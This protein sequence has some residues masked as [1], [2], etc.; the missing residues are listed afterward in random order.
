VRFAPS[1]DAVI[2]DST[3][4][5]AEVLNCALLGERLG[6]DVSSA[7]VVR[8]KP[9]RRL[10][11]VYETSQGP[12]LGKVRA[13][14]RASTPYRL[15]TNLFTS[16]FGDQEPD[17]I[18]VPEPIAVLEDLGVWFQRLVPGRSAT[19]IFTTEE[20]A[21][22]VELAR[23]SA[24]AAHKVH[25]VNIKTRRTHTIYDELQVL[26]RRLSE[27]ECGANS[28]AS[29]IANVRKNC[30]ALGQTLGARPV[31][32]IHRDYYPDQLV[33]D[34]SRVSI[35]DFDLYCAGDPAVDIGNFLAHLTELALR[36]FGD[37]QALRV[38]REAFLTEYLSLAGAQNCFA[39]QVYETLSLARHISLSTEF[40]E[41]RT[42]TENLLSFT[43][44]QL[45]LVGA[46]C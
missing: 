21:E 7:S 27:L 1:G 20:A 6:I 40:A 11:V 36:T 38:L 22:L 44:E 23:R 31:A 26:D 13:N 24:R 32:G 2:V 4:P 25:T 19:D 5:V 35:V 15:L 3:M 41:R 45:C 16:G 9:G 39:V 37:P 34:G 18:V 17:E 43:E 30:R 12:L 14:H 8:H 29:R 42:F 28:L 33:I 10:L 46:R